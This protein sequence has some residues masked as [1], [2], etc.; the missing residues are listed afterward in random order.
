MDGN[1]RLQIMGLSN[2]AA[3][4]LGDIFGADLIDVVDLDEVTQDGG[5]LV[6][7]FETWPEDSADFDWLCSLVRDTLAQRGIHGAQFA[8]AP[9]RAI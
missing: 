4:R 9:P 5:F 7:E 3:A 1:V 8:L 6:C 2:Q